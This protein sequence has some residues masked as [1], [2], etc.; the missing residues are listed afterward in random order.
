MGRDKFLGGFLGLQVV[1]DVPVDLL[2]FSL[3]VQGLQQG[4]VVLEVVAHGL[5]L[6]VMGLQLLGGF[7]LKQ[8]IL[9]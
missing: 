4:E 6:P 1:L 2:P 8:G 7:L 9:S 3:P 5:Q